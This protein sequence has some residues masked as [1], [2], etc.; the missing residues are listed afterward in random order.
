MRLAFTFATVLA[1]YAQPPQT[2]PQDPD[3]ARL[4]GMVLNSATGEPLRKT[5]LTLRMNVAAPAPNQPRPPQS[6]YTVTSDVTGKFEFANVEPGDYQLTARHDGFADA[7]V[8]NT[9]NGRRVEPILL[10]R[11]D[12]KT[13]VT[14]K[15]IPYGALAGV[16]LDEDGDPIR[17]LRV[18]AMSWRYTTNGREL[19]EVRSASSNDLGE[20]RIFDLPAG[21]YFLKSNPA[22]FTFDRDA[23]TPSESY[24]ALF[25]PGVP[26]VSQAI[27]QDLAPGQQLRGLT[28]NLRKVHAANISG[29]VIAPP[30]ASKVEAGRLIYS[31]GSS[32][33][34]STGVDD[35]SGKFVLPSVPPGN[36]YLT[37]S[38]IQDGRRYDTILPMEVGYTD[39]EGIELRPIAPADIGGQV[40][41]EG[42]PA[43]DLT[44]IGITLNGAASGHQGSAPAPAIKADGTF[45]LRG[46]TPGFYRVNV[47]RLQQTYI[48]SIRF[49]TTDITDTLLDLSGGVPPRTELAI[50]LGNDGGEIAGTVLNEKSEPVDVAMVTLLPAGSTRRVRSYF[51]TATV[52]ASGHF[53]L[54]GVAPGSYRILAWDH[55][56]PNAVFYDPE[57]LKPYEGGGQNLEVQSKGKHTAELKLVVNKDPDDRSR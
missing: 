21:R 13:N 8:G 16:T 33:S 7:H 24:A 12:R 45:T 38:Y 50:V 42:D 22:Q 43:F 23:R 40:S 49:G 30:D 51:R 37:G 46:I 53:T 35:K 19:A 28:F 15:L 56:D 3:K 48:K 4:E 54:R 6:T 47:S 52:D 34:T 27:V 14:V 2:V 57:F 5:T 39:I 18:S 25:Y 29:K 31:E 36:I 32:T 11:A 9:G 17:N 44:R 1:L 55:V 20:F 10:N 41:V 26:Q